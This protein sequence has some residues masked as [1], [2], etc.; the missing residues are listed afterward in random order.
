MTRHNPVVGMMPQIVDARRGMGA[1]VDPAQLLAQS[2]EDPVH[3]A[4]TQCASK[5]PAPRGDEERRLLG[6]CDLRIAQPTI[7]SQRLQRARMHRHMAGLGKLGLT[8]RQQARL[9]IGVR[10]EQMYRLGDPQTGRRQQA[11]Q[12]FVGCPA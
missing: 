7:S 3:L 2:L 10:I 12:G 11:E 6:R 4:K 9:Q 1:T 8:H 5:V